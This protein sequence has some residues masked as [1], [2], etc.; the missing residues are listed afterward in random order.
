M[1]LIPKTNEKQQGN[2]VSSDVITRFFSHLSKLGIASGD[3]LLATRHHEL[4]W[5]ISDFHFPV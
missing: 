4:V 2:F 5:T 3:R 1:F